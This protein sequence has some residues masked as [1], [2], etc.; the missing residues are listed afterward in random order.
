MYIAK[1]NCILHI[2]IT[3]VLYIF[4]SKSEDLNIHTLHDGMLNLLREILVRF[5]KPAVLVDVSGTDLLK[6]EYDNVANQLEDEELLIDHEIHDSIA[7]DL[8][9]GNLTANQRDNFY[10]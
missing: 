4:H 6:V 9:E 2:E 5:V 1:T 3:S 8:E 7:S 10:K